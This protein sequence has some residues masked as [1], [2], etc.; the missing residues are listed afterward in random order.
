MTKKVAF[1]YN[2]DLEEF[3]YGENHPMQPLRV[4]MTFDLL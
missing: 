2:E 3:S 1:L 4:A